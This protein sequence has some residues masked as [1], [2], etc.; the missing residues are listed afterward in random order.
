MTKEETLE[1]IAKKMKEIEILEYEKRL[2]QEDYVKQI[3]NVDLSEHISFLDLA[4]VFRNR[5]P[6]ITKDKSDNFLFDTFMNTIKDTLSDIWEDI[7]EP[8]EFV[9][10]GF[11]NV[12][13]Y[14]FSFIYKGQ[15]FC[16]EIPEFR[17]INDFHT[18][19]SCGKYNLLHTPDCISYIIYKCENINDIKQNIKNDLETYIKVGIK[20]HD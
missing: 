5:P 11:Y 9:P 18:A 1:L 13:Q 10:I 7:S 3:K 2:L 16:L 17:E 12:A 8:F 19:L 14:Q 15:K 6:K 4:E 20:D